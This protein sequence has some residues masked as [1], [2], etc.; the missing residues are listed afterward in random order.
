MAAPM[1]RT[2]DRISRLITWGILALVILFVAAIRIRLRE[3]PLERDEGEYA[4]VG[5]LLLHGIPP[6]QLAYT[7]K[8]PGTGAAYAMI[9]AIFGQT[10]AGIHLGLLLVNAATTVLVFLLARQ[11][12]NDI[13][14]FVAAATFALLSV[15]P[16]VYGTAAHAEHFVLLPALA[17]FLVL[18]RALESSKHWA[19]FAAG[20]LFGLSFLM[21]Q[22]GICFGICGGVY[23][24]HHVARGPGPVPWRDLTIKGAWYLSGAVLPLALVGVMLCLAG[25][26]KTFW[27]WTVAY[28]REYGGIETLG[29][30]FDNFRSGFEYVMLGSRCLWILAGFGAIQ[31]CLRWKTWP[32]P[33]LTA[34]LFLFSFF[35]VCP[36]F[37]FRN[38]YFILLLPA[39]GMAAGLMVC[40]AQNWFSGTTPY[41]FVPVF[42]FIAA[43]GYSVFQQSNLLLRLPPAE[44]GRLTYRANPFP[45]AGEIAR[46]I[47]G[48]STRDE[49]IAVLGS[50]PEI[51]FLAD[52][53]SATGYL[54]AY[55][56]MEPQPYALQMQQ[57]MIHEIETAKPDW[58]VLV[59]IGASWDKRPHSNVLIFDWFFNHYSPE[60]LET[61]GVI[62]LV[63]PVQT[64]YYWL[65][66]GQALPPRSDF[67]LEIFKR[68]SA[69]AK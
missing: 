46:Y 24:V 32:R 17:G 51:Y 56:L 44:V 64:D 19:F 49:T 65:T 41:R 52:R 69:V 25:T 6:Y 22:S 18:L 20:L 23:L 42:V 31:L 3:L 50:E 16:A 39:V 27:F 40:S 55:P 68:K 45:E 12:M 62:N 66:E 29:Q 2:D 35:S 21:K 13:G 33:I 14:A 5:Q 34:G 58:V 47:K 53:R 26:F 60:N 1:P 37:Y 67:C 28:A 61:V 36:G 38:H 15:S 43:W 11:L 63:S 8:L 48:H 7:M 57:Q 59:R 30:G 54:Y 9:M 10:A 4:Y